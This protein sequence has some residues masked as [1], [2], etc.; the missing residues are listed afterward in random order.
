M[1]AMA[2]AFGRPVTGVP[3]TFIGDEV[4]V[5]YTDAYGRQIARRSDEVT[6]MVLLGV[7]AEEIVARGARIHL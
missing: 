1:E 5:G 2:A 6:P 7:A 4:W 3:M